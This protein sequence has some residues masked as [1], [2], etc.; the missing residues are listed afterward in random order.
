MSYR[1]GII[2]ELPSMRKKI[3]FFSIFLMALCKDAAWSGSKRGDKMDC[4]SVW[5]AASACRGDENSCHCFCP[6]RYMPDGE[7]D[8]DSGRSDSGN[9][10]GIAGS[11]L[12]IFSDR[13]FEYSS[14][15]AGNYLYDGLYC[16]SQDSSVYCPG[17]FWESLL[18]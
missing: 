1:C 11:R 10:L 14:Y 6:G 7:R 9:Q 13:K 4:P 16:S 17:C 18:L 12:C 8:P 5:T 2:I 3:F 15:R